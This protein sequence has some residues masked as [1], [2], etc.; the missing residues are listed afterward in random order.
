MFSEDRIA[1]WQRHARDVLIRTGTFARLAVVHVVLLPAWIRAHDAEIPARAKILVA[2]PRRNDHD[3]TR[4]Q[5]LHDSALAAKLHF[6][7]AAMA[8][9]HLVRSTVVMMI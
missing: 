2:H 4:A 3:I 6:G 9:K 8:T 5:I 1:F 7:R